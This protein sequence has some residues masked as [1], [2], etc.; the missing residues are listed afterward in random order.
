MDYKSFNGP[1]LKEQF[2]GDEEILVEMIKNFQNSCPNL[3]KSLRSSV[4][5]KDADKLSLSA[6]TFKGVFSNFFA[7]E[8]VKLAYELEMCGRKGQ[9][10]NSQSLLERLE[11]E[12]ALLLDEILLLKKSLNVLS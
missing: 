12:L 5:E 1:L 11:R 3:L 2:E 7:E 6:H 8:A 9:L 4:E 10:E